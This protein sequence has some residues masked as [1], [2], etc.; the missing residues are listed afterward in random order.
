MTNGSGGGGIQHRRQG[1]ATACGGTLTTAT[2]AGM[3]A[4]LSYP[5]V[6]PRRSLVELAEV[7]PL[8]KPIF[9]T[10]EKLEEATKGFDKELEREF[11]FCLC[12][13]P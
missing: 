13:S 11:S 5:C 9:F 12:K 2:A 10:Y 7:I 4:K 6:R 3:M 1:G 8:L